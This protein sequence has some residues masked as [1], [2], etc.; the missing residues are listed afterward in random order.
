MFFCSIGPW[1]VEGFTCT[2]NY[3]SWDDSGE[4]TPQYLDRHKVRCHK[5]T[6]INSFRLEADHSGS[7]RY[8]YT[9]CTLEHGA[10]ATCS[11]NMNVTNYTVDRKAN[12]SYL[13]LQNVNCNN[14]YLTDFQLERKPDGGAVRYVFGCCE[15]NSNNH[16][17]TWQKQTGF[18][19]RQCQREYLL[20]E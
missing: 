18:V 8:Q 17:N 2:T 4:S 10:H 6:A 11:P 16:K 15:D 14:Q 20:F 1:I 5:G 13:A 12:A 19:Y 7:F 9:C 3:T